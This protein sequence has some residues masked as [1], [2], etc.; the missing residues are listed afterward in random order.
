MSMRDKISEGGRVPAV[1][2]LVACALAGGAALAASGTDD[3]A[4]RR[5]DAAS[6]LVNVAAFLAQAMYETGGLVMGG[7]EEGTVD[8]DIGPDFGTELFNDNLDRFAEHLDRA[9]TTCPP[10]GTTGLRKLINGFPNIRVKKLTLQQKLLMDLTI[11]LHALVMI[12]I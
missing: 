11:Y 1:A 9:I 10:L 8:C 5:R 12:M 2:C 4:V 7:W 3:A 6:G